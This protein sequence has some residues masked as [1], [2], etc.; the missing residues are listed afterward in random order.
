M[1]ADLAER[2]D[3]REHIRWDEFIQRPRATPAHAY[4]LAA[5][6]AICKLAYGAETMHLAV[7]DGRRGI[8]AAL[9]LVWERGLLRGRRLS[10]LMH[11]LRGGPIGDDERSLKSVTEAARRVAAERSATR[12]LITSETA[13]L[14]QLVS[15]LRLLGHT[16]SWVTALPSEP[17]ELRRRWAKESKNLARNLKR[18]EK[19]DVAVHAAR[20]ARDVWHFYR[21]YAGT[22]R[23]HGVLPRSWLEVYYAWRFLR[24]SGRCRVYV[25]EH[26]GRAVAGALFLSAG[27]TLEL[28]Y[29]GSETRALD[30]RPNHAVYW[31]AIE[32]GIAAGLRRLDWGPAPA[33]SSLGGFKRQ[34]STEALP[35]FSYAY[36]PQCAGPPDK[37]G[38]KQTG[39]QP[40]YPGHTVTSDTAAARA[41]HRVPASLLG[42]AATV[43]HRIL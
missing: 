29:A 1:S 21:L 34:W 11:S 35:V 32:S 16:T 5:W 37:A 7:R 36:E 12:L 43:A 39:T 14:E 13:G 6:A 8:T 15:H 27:D 3:P 28:L 30:V 31:H 22:M 26:A 9:P 18:S 10:S 20:T 4:H 24:Q 33:E 40:E 41:F 19:S 23:R 17:A 25:A 42:I 2:L 38:I